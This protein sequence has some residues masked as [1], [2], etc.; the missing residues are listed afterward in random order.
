MVKNK[1]IL[2]ASQ[3]AG[4]GNALLPIIK[5]LQ[6]RFEKR[7]FA[8]KESVNIF[9]KG[10]INFLNCNHLDKSN[11]FELFE[12][13]NPDV[14]ITGASGNFCIEKQAILFSKMRK[15]I[16]I[17]VLD[18]WENYWQRFSDLEENRK[19]VYL[20]EYIF[21]MDELAK[22]EMLEQG[23]P[24][25]R[26]IITGNPFFDENLKLDLKEL[27]SNSI[28]L[29]YISQMVLDFTPGKKQDYT[30]RIDKEFIRDLFSI[31]SELKIDKKLKIIVRPHPKEKNFDFKKHLTPYNFDIIIDR[32]SDINDL[33][34]QANII[35]GKDSMVLFQAAF[36][37]KIVLS[38]QPSINKEQNV[39]L[40][41]K[42][43]LSYPSYTKRKFKKDLFEAIQGKI[44][45]PN[46]S[47]NELK[48]YLEG[49]STE[50]AIS[51]IIKILT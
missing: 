50:R 6:N 28:T 16:S 45:K 8:T 40:T 17:S 32:E 2:F 18:M 29:L 51:E 19:F 21:I 43:G 46:L 31:L 22:R 13:F 4:S 11:L 33:I 42:F 27:Q 15:I 14:I 36:N 25:E 24:E 35:V 26:L 30:G 39:L 9:S 38:Y 23:F 49:K 44:K 5:K 41:N 34:S 20:P 1:K 3:D 47:N 12:E 37:R 7:V 10:N 48:F